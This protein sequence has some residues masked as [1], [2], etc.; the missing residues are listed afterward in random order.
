MNR[1]AT[2]LLDAGTSDVALVYR[3]VEISFGDLRAR[4]ERVA[5]GLRRLGVGSGDRVAIWLPNVPAWLEVF[6]A[7]CRLGA[8]AVSVNTRFR[9]SE[10]EDIVGRSRAKL[11]VL[12]PDF[13]GIDFLGILADIEGAHLPELERVVLYSEAEE[14]QRAETVL[15][16]EALPFETLAQSTPAAEPAGDDLEQS[17]CVIFTTSGTTRAPKFVL[18]SQSGLV[19][20]AHEVADAFSYRRRDV[21]LAQVMPFCGVF[22]FCQVLAGLAAGR[23]SHLQTS[24]APRE[25]LALVT[26]HR[27]THMHGTD[28][29]WQRLFDV[30]SPGTLTSLRACGF[31]AFTMQPAEL[32]AAADLHGVPLVG[33]YGMSEI[34]AL[35]AARREDDPAGERQ[36]CGGYPVSPSARVRVRDPESG[37]LLGVG[38]QGELEVKGPSQ[39]IGYFENAEATAATLTEDGYV[40]TGDLGVLDDDGSFEYVA[41]MGDALRLGGFLVSPAEIEAHLETHPRVDTAQV[42]GVDTPAG[43]RC[44]AFVVGPRVSESETRSDEE[45]RQHCARAL[46]KFKVPERVLVLAEFP[47]TASANGTKIQKAVLRRWAEESLSDPVS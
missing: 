18:H 38:G 40:R 39:M 36:R 11:L 10:V 30:A 27:I 13:R 17:G 1:H 22:G 42:V 16:K 46:A 9:A 29:M 24:F 45:L 23:P 47:T 15:G 37:Q 19:R 35:F 12:W 4:S 25:L 28:D 2:S 43:P 21:V 34:Q 14:P 8:I 41:R 32:L 7:C 5:G 6:F 26:E 44:C 33:L 20:H 31:A 3:D